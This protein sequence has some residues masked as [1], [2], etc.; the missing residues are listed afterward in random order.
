MTAVESNRGAEYWLSASAFTAYL[1][2]AEGQSIPYNV[3][4]GL[5][6]R[7]NKTVVSFED[8]KPKE[9]RILVGDLADMPEADPM[10]CQNAFDGKSPDTKCAVEC[11]LPGY[12]TDRKTAAVRFH[13]SHT[14]HRAHGTALLVKEMGQW[15]VQ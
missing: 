14:P 15:K 9:T 3:G 4:A 10:Q 8:F 12:S 6:N 2:V 1:N 7:R 5:R 13:V 11:Y